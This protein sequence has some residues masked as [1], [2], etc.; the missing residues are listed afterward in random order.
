MNTNHPGRHGPSVRNGD[1]KRP[2]RPPRL[3]PRS[4]AAIDNIGV[5]DQADLLDPELDDQPG[6]RNDDGTSIL[7]DVRSDGD[8]D[9]RKERR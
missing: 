1:G 9:E 8:E 4:Q 2:M 7:D 5:D 6:D 3:D